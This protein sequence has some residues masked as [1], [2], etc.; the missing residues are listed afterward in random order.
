MA[1]RGLRRP[2]SP[3]TPPPPPPPLPSLPSPRPHHPHSLPPLPMR[4]CHRCRRRHH[5]FFSSALSLARHRCRIPVPVKRIG[6]PNLQARDNRVCQTCS[7]LPSSLHS[8][9]SSLSLPSQVSDLGDFLS[10]ILFG[11]AGSLL[12]LSAPAVALRTPLC[13]LPFSLSIPHWVAETIGA[14]IDKD[15]DT[16]RCNSNSILGLYW[17][18]PAAHGSF[19][20]FF[21]VCHGAPASDL[22]TCGCTPESPRL[23]GIR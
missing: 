8:P 7:S 4:V 13:R 2:P 12:C 14:L 9:P 5:P 17:K 16:A 23:G 22:W 1:L 15:Y 11:A 21:S 18:M 19:C 20:S 3:V 6:V 10:L